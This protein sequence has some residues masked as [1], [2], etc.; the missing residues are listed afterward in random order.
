MKV[1]GAFWYVKV[2]LGALLATAGVIFVVLA[3]QGTPEGLPVV[4]A[5]KDL[6]AGAPAEMRDFRVLHLPKQA[7]PVGAIT[8]LQRVGGE[9]LVRDLPA[10]TVLTQETLDSDGWKTLPQ[11]FSQVA[12]HLRDPP[13]FLEVGDEIEVWGEEAGC[14]VGDCPVVL[15]SAPAILTALERGS[16]GGFDPEEQATAHLQVRYADV[17][18][19]LQAAEGGSIHF[20]TRSAT[21]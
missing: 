13:K 7:I 10:G 2:A 6:E 16:A 8:D 20:V 11:G 19:V 3:L 17:G 21:R 4:V 12:V 18:K 1:R 14:E 15:L 5:K 9:P